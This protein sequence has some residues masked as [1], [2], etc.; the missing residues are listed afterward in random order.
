MERRLCLKRNCVIIVLF[1]CAIFGITSY[2]Y[3]KSHPYYIYV[4]NQIKDI[5]GLSQQ[6]INILDGCYHVYLDG[7]SNLGVQ[8]R[9]LYEPRKYPDAYVNKIFD[10][11]FGPIEDRENENNSEIIF[12]VGLEPNPHHS[13]YL[14]RVESRYNKCGWRVKFFTET[15]ASDT[16]GGSHFSTDDDS[17]NLEWGGGILPPS[18]NNIAMHTVPSN[19]RITEGPN[20]SSQIKLMRLS[21]CLKN[22]VKT[23]KIPSIGIMKRPPKIVMKMGIEGSEI[24]V[25]PDLIFTGGLQYIN[26]IMIEWHTNHEVLPERKMAQKQ[27]ETIV[28]TLSE[29]SKTMKSSEIDFQ[30]VNRD[31]ESY[32]TSK[33]R[34]PKC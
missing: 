2:D 9:K 28:K 18:I 19:N 16:N 31:D 15:A 12:A 32:H 14:K 30:L 11:Y 1:M 17:K 33:F 29:Y 4:K 21:D 5:P 13:K 8:V 20:K 23:R 26:A 24:D 25:M 22:V 10:T 3:I 6:K 7:V 27:L 34:L